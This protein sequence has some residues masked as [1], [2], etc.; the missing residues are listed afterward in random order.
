MTNA[1]PIDRG[2]D[3]VE[4]VRRLDVPG[5]NANAADSLHPGAA[6]CGHFNIRI[7]RDGTWF[8]HG[9]PITRK[10]LVKLFATVLRRDESGRYLLVTPAERGFIDVDDAPFTAVAVTASGSGRTQ[11]LVFRTNLDEEVI[12]GPSHPIRVAEHRE[13]GEPSP[14]ILVRDGL[15]ALI[16]RPVFY[17]LAERGVSEVLDG[18]EAFGIWSEN[19]FF[20]L[21]SL[22]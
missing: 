19:I 2:P 1:P 9:S 21:G 10:P 11:R 6:A 8:Y 4:L 18:A 14:Y 22:K 12:A 13:T 17:E 16:A 3:P 7:A 20:R 5:G 15:E